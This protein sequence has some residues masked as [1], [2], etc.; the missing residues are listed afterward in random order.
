MNKYFYYIRDQAGRDASTR[1]KNVEGQ[2]IVYTN[3]AY[4]LEASRKMPIHQYHGM[5]TKNDI[6]Y[7]FY[8][9]LR[10]LQVVY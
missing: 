5:W 10:D 3:I 7:P 4:C 1:I 6:N 2:G 9:D 8:C